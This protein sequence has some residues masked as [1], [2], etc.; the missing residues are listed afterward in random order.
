MPIERAVHTD[1]AIV[2]NRA[3]D[4]LHA[5]VAPVILGSIVI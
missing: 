2:A 3:I 4:R 5:L 1:P